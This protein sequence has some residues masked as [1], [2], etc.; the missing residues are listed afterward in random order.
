MLTPKL[1]NL[2]KK[3][4]Q[5]VAK[6]KRK[7]LKANPPAA[8]TSKKRK[9]KNTPKEIIDSGLKKNQEKNRL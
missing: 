6:V 9:T 5:A 4:N 3:K 1:Y 8:P 2:A 7:N